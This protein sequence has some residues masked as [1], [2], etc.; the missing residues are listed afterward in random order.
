[1]SSLDEFQ[2]RYLDELAAAVGALDQLETAAQ[3]E[4]WVSGAIA[5]WQALSGSI[6]D[7][8]PGIA[9]DSPL[10]SE[11]IAWFIGGPIPVDPHPWIQDLGQHQLERAVRLGEP[12]LPDEVALIFEYTLHGQSD[13]DLSVSIDDG[14]LT[15]VTIGPPGLAE[16]VDDQVESTLV[17]EEVDPDT[18]L[19]LA[20]AALERPLEL[21]SPASEANV[22]LL[23]RRVGGK[24][25]PPATHSTSREIPKRDPEDDMWCADV[26]RSAFRSVLGEAAPEAVEAARLAFVSLVE[27]RN[28]DALTVLE[29]AGLAADTTIDRAAQLSL[30]GAYFAPADLSAHTDPQFEALIELEPVDWVGVVLGLA[31]SKDSD[32]PVDGASMVNFINRAPEITSTIPSQ[33]AAR[34]AWAFEQMLFAWE[35][36]GVINEDGRVTEAG[37]WLLPHAFVAKVG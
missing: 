9:E 7:L 6:D 31:R 16:G 27:Q 26:V 12:A 15:G 11:L 17:L 2:A 21:L 20:D 35:V 37:R 34:L 36:T 19:G 30:A 25:R 28:P 24:F 4:A 13:H 33:D 10:A 22:P 29:V 32:P 18:A 8:G 14:L 23:S 5:E 1:M 3:V